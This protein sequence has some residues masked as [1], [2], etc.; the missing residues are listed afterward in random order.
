MN[1][2]RVL[3]S[4]VV[5]N[6]TIAYAQTSAM[7]AEIASCPAT[8]DVSE[9][10]YEVLIELYNSTCAGVASC[11]WS[12]PAPPVCDGYGITCNTTTGAITAMYL[13]R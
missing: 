12:H 3:M 6:E 4:K 5:D 10:E 7:M 1:A 8:V 2:S 11:Q 9:E 13:W